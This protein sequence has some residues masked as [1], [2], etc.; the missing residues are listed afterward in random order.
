MTDYVFAENYFEESRA[1]VWREIISR[2]KPVKVLEIGSF[3]GQATCFLIE[4]IGEYAEPVIHC[5]DTWQGGE[6]HSQIDMNSIEQNFLNNVQLANSKV[7]NKA[8]VVIHKGLSEQHLVNLLAN[9]EAAGFDLIYVDGSHQAPDVL[10]GLLMSYQLCK[11]GGI[12]IC[13]DYLWRMGGTLLHEPKVA[14]DAFTNIYRDK[15]SIIMAPLHQLYIY[16]NK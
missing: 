13:D 2:W 11:V 3:E 5:I 14:I 10:F 1:V 4:K 16:K 6:E 15:V 8:S 9:G 12:I 7:G